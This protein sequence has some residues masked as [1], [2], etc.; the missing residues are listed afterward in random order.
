MKHD[1]Q[2]GQL[3]DCNRAYFR[4]HGQKLLI[5]LAFG[6]IMTNQRAELDLERANQKARFKGTVSQR[7]SI[8]IRAGRSP[9]R[10][11]FIGIDELGRL[12]CLLLDNGRSERRT[13]VAGDAQKVWGGMLMDGRLFTL[14]IERLPLY[15]QGEGKIGS[16]EIKSEINGRSQLLF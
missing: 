2:S 10:I 3:P 16:V 12:D 4:M 7:D 1:K 13:L 14:T 6:E 15:L 8:V 5:G 9:F 11:V